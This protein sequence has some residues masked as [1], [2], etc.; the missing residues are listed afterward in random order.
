M[1]PEVAK[2]EFSL[3]KIYRNPVDNLLNVEYLIQSRG[4]AADM[5]FLKFLVNR[6]GLLP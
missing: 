6:W 4:R 2:E 1:L 3:A 5:F